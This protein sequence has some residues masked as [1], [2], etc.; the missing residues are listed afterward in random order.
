MT[1]FT[2]DMDQLAAE[3]ASR[4]GQAHVALGDK[5]D[6]F[7]TL[8]P[9]YAIQMKHKGASSEDPPDLPTFESFQAKIHAVK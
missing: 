3:I 5:L 7:K 2:D 6:A 8:M 4:A 1:D 9:Y